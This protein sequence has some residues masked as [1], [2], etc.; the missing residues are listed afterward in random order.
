MAKKKD[1]DITEKIRF[2]DEM[3]DETVQAILAIFSFLLTLLSLLAAFDKAGEV[4]KYGYLFFTRLFGVGY[5][6]IPITF[7]ML[8]VSF[9][10]GLKKKFEVSKMLGVFIFF[11]S[12]LGLIHISYAGAGGTIG[13]WIATP[14]TAML[15][16][17]AT[18]CLLV[19]LLAISVI[20]TFNL[21]FTLEDIA[22]WRRTKIET[23][24]KIKKNADMD[25][26]EEAAV[27][28][29][30]A[31]AINA[32]NRTGDIYNPIETAA[33]KVGTTQ[34]GDAIAAAV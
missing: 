11:V 12:G 25:A 10:Q 27:E 32:G 34:M 14:L 22:F 23:E 3:R 6:L 28:K 7:S 4:G 17:P 29:A 24:K 19:A 21:Y 20:M 26:Y 33:K 8:G 5:F 16:V 31:T 1:S 18:A 9:L 2:W 15:D 30:V 13:R